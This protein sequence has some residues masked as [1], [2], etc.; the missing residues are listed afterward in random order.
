MGLDVGDTLFFPNANGATYE[1]TI[2]QGSENFI[3]VAVMVSITT[4]MTAADK[5]PKAKF[6]GNCYFKVHQSIRQ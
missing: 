6:Y 3:S 1:I 4:E 2:V 5:L